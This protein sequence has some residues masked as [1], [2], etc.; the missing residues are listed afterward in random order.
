MLKVTRGNRRNNNTHPAG[1]AWIELQAPRA[2][3][4]PSHTKPGNQYKPASTAFIYTF[5]Q[6]LFIPFPFLKGK[7]INFE[8]ISI[9][10]EQFGSH[11]RGGGSFH[12]K[13][14][15]A[16][17]PNCSSFPLRLLHNTLAYLLHVHGFVTFPPC[18]LKIGGN[19][20]Q[21]NCRENNKRTTMS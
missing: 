13:V 14:L 12:R 9:Q 18:F 1:E 5:P 4:K 2:T 7:G 16:W 11:W 17:V 10:A 21:S 19:G 6:P 8:I 3:S 20:G 15:C